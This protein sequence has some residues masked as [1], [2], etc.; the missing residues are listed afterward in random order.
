MLLSYQAE[1]VMSKHF[2]LLLKIYEQN[3][4]KVVGQQSGKLEDD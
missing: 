1:R 4:F 3:T 2:L